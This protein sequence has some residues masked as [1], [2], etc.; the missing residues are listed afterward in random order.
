[1]SKQKLITILAIIAIICGSISTYLMEGETPAVESAPV[2]VSGNIDS[3]F[4][5]TTDTIVIVDTIK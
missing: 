3:I 2:V 4:F 1:M 5:E